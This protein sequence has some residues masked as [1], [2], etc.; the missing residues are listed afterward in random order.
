MARPR[1]A[2]K[3]DAVL[4]A[5][6]RT[7]ASQGTGAATALIAKEAGVSNGSLFTYFDTK[8]D[9]LN[10]LYIQLKTEMAVAALDGFPAQGDL[11]DQLLHVW[12][13]WLHWATTSPEKRRTLAHL[14]VSDDI[15]VASHQ[16]ARRTMADIARL[17]ERCLEHGQMHGTPLEFMLALMNAVAD[18][19]IDFMLRDPANAQKHAQSG[20]KALWHIV[21]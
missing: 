12:G 2:A 16:Q 3:H 8:A 9:L 11:R 18:T 10:Q 14:D 7:I 6:V 4:S 15:T 19:T 20:F 17:L 21:A 1:S 5:A 13:Q